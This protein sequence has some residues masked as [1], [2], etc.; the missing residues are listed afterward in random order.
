MDSIKQFVIVAAAV[1]FA[2]IVVSRLVHHSVR[3][4]NPPPVGPPIPDSIPPGNTGFI[5]PVTATDPTN[6]LGQIDETPPTASLGLDSAQSPLANQPKNVGATGPVYLPPP[7]RSF[8]L[9]S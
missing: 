4:V 6:A 7:P 2:E 3:V 8:G 1:I 9:D 5:P